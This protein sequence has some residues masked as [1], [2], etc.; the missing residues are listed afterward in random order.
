M[1]Q[2]NVIYSLNQHC[3]NWKVIVFLLATCPSFALVLSAKPF[4]DIEIEGRY[5]KNL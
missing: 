3:N 2:I 4:Q 5:L 1:N